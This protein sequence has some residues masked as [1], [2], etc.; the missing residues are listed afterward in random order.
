M[1]RFYELYSLY[2]QKKMSI[3]NYGSSSTWCLCEKLPRSILHIAPTPELWCDV[4]G[5]RKRPRSCSTS[6][7]DEERDAEQIRPVHPSLQKPAHDVVCSKVSKTPKKRKPTR[8]SSCIKCGRQSRPSKIQPQE[9]NLKNSNRVYMGHFGYYRKPQRLHA[10]RRDGMSVSEVRPVPIAPPSPPPSVSPPTNESQSVWEQPNKDM[11]KLVAF[12]HEVFNRPPHWRNRQPE[13][14]FVSDFIPLD[15]PIIDIASGAISKRSS[16]NRPLCSHYSRPLPPLSRVLSKILDKHKVRAKG[17]GLPAKQDVYNDSSAGSQFTPFDSYEGPSEDALVVESARQMLRQPNALHIPCRSDLQSSRLSTFDSEP[18]SDCSFTSAPFDMPTAPVA[19]RQCHSYKVGAPLRLRK[20]MKAVAQSGL[21]DSSASSSSTGTSSH[22]SA[23]ST[24]PLL[25]ESVRSCGGEEPPRT[26]KPDD[27]DIVPIAIMEKLL[28]LIDQQPTGDPTAPDPNVVLTETEAEMQHAPLMDV[29]VKSGEVLDS[30]NESVKV[31][32]QF[33]NKLHVEDTYSNDIPSTIRK[34]DIRDKLHSADSPLSELHSSNDI[35]NEFHLNSPN[36][37][38][39]DA[40]Y[41]YAFSNGNHDECS[42]NKVRSELSNNGGT[43]ISIWSTIAGLF[44]TKP[45]L[46]KPKSSSASLNASAAI[47][48]V[49]EELKPLKNGENLHYGSIKQSH[50]KA[51]EEFPIC[52][53][54]KTINRMIP[55]SITNKNCHKCGLNRANNFECKN[56]YTSQSSTS[57][58]NQTAKPAVFEPLKMLWPISKTSDEIQY[59]KNKKQTVNL[60]TLSQNSKCFHKFH[61]LAKN[62]KELKKFHNIEGFQRSFKT[63]TEESATSLTIFESCIGSERKDIKPLELLQR[64]NHNV[65]KPPT[66]LQVA[67]TI[68]TIHFECSE[69]IKPKMVSFAIEMG[70]VMYS[71]LKT[72]RLHKHYGLL[73]FRTPD[74]QNVDSNSIIKNDFKILKNSLHPESSNHFEESSSECNK[75]ASTCQLLPEWPALPF[76]RR[77]RCINMKTIHQFNFA[78]D[79]E[80]SADEDKNSQMQR[81]KKY[82]WLG[83]ELVQKK[84]HEMMTKPIRLLN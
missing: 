46:S 7:S 27:T 80:K 20:M 19:E 24:L 21:S 6:S 16:P 77:K 65:P 70:R 17:G 76:K 9:L 78:R 22:K 52:R 26:K 34:S 82:M 1:F 60:T 11:P 53:G 58:S 42:G 30:R 84:I 69:I 40:K 50:T 13:N 64:L 37:S 59:L 66:F 33:V 48:N 35:S 28:W 47:L 36:K 3:S 68:E 23:S 62:A 56:N 74:N 72:L 31:L 25:Q 5:R 29:T 8:L 15:K 38:A 51:A 71:T 39:G 10:K 12:A 45:K 54:K 18:S 67:N 14:L 83:N 57:R 44:K 41:F 2:S 79:D 55:P 75:G 63:D 81:E 43:S 61:A 49:T 73:E 4:C 32:L